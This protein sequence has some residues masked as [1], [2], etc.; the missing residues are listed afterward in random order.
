M[1]AKFRFIQIRKKETDK[2][3]LKKDCACD[4][5]MSGNRGN[6]LRNNRIGYLLRYDNSGIKRK[7]R[8]SG[9]RGN[10]ITKS[11]STLHSCLHYIIVCDPGSEEPVVTHRMY[12]CLSSS[13]CTRPFNNAHPLNPCLL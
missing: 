9:N 12:S 4:T 8:E 10:V 13:I 6:H 7:C 3:V 11:P 5:V 2:K 1:S